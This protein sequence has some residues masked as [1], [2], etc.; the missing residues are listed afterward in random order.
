MIGTLALKSSKPPNA[1]KAL[2]LGAVKSP[3][4]GAVSSNRFNAH[5]RRSGQGDRAAV[6]PSAQMVRPLLSSDPQSSSH[7]RS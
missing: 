7:W 4:I 1:A 6:I 3:A 5:S 2:A